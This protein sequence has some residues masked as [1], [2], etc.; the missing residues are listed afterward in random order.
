M[1]NNYKK[2]LSYVLVLASLFI[3]VLFTKD[4]VFDMQANLDIKNSKNQEIKEKREEFK[5]FTEIKNK[6]KKEEN[7]EVSKYTITPTEDEIIDYIYSMVEDWNLWKSVPIS[8]WLATIKSI[9]MTKWKKNELWFLESDITLNLSV[10]KESRLKDIL[11]FFV[12]DK[13]KYKFFID[14]FSYEKPKITDVINN[15]ASIDITIPL[16]IFYK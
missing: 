7:T 1:N 5:K 2:I 12:S 15:N 4:Y 14:S 9:S 8:H 6:L 16:K 11:N 3:I 10:Q 13:S